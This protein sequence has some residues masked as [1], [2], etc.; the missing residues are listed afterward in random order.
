MD[1]LAQLYSRDELSASTIYNLIAQYS[2]LFDLIYSLEHTKMTVVIL[3][4]FLDLCK[5]IRKESEKLAQRCP[6]NQS[7]DSGPGSMALRAW[8]LS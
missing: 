8:F 6:A 3:R 5:W 1:I 2:N 4:T 7:P